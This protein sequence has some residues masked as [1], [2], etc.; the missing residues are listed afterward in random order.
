MGLPWI[1]SPQLKL[2]SPRNDMKQLMTWTWIENFI[3]FCSLHPE[4]GTTLKQ[5]LLWFSENHPFFLTWPEM[6]I[7]REFLES[8]TIHGLSYI[9]TAKVGYKHCHRR[10]GP[11]SW[12][13]LT[14]AT[15]LGYITSSTCQ[16]NISILA[17]IKQ[18]NFDQSWLQNIYKDSASQAKIGNKMLTK[19]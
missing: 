10:N 18:Q 3:I 1:E 11:E 15:S 4:A 7:F 14:K 6:E 9:S 16:P 13:L 8:S 12:V 2:T 5:P 17:K 19:L